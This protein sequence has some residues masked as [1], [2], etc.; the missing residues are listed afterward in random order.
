ML[1]LELERHGIDEAVEERCL[2]LPKAPHIVAGQSQVALVDPPKDE[3]TEQRVARKATAENSVE[4]DAVAGG[5]P[6]LSQQHGW[7]RTRA[8]IPAF[9]AGQAELEGRGDRRAK[10]GKIRRVFD[11]V[12]VSD[13]V[14]AGKS[15][16][17]NLGKLTA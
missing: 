1:A 17:F 16:P 14:G 13:P 11:M 2:F 9:D 12:R 15:Q 5:L 10:A 8:L 3:V 7:D 4:I 6:R